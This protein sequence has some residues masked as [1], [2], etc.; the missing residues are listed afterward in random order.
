MAMAS[1]SAESSVSNSARGSSTA[2]IMRIC[3]F[4]AWPAPTIAFFT[5]FGAYSATGNAGPRRHQHGDAAR[6]PELQRRGRVAVDEGRLDRRL[7]RASELRITRCSPSWMTQSR[8]ASESVLF[9]RIVPAATKESREPET[10]HDA[11]AGAPEVRD[12]CR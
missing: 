8:S 4:S 2:T 12:R 11:P 5:A 10:L 7:V 9:G 1:A 3:C 6:L